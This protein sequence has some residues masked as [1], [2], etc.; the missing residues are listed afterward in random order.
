MVVGVEERARIG[1]VGV[2]TRPGA[3]VGQV[4]RQGSQRRFQGR[5]GR[6]ARHDVDLVPPVEAPLHGGQVRL[7]TGE[8][9]RRQ[10]NAQVL[11][12][13]D[14]IG[15][16]FAFVEIPVAG[17]GEAPQGLRQAPEAN[18]GQG[19]G[20]LTHRREAPREKYLPAVFVLRQGPGFRADLQGSVPVDFHAGL[21]EAYCG[22]QQLGEGTG[23]AGIEHRAETRHHAGHRHGPG[24]ADIGIADD[25]WP[26]EQIRTRAVHE[27]VVRR[28]H[29]LGRPDAKLGG[30]APMI[31]RVVVHEVAA[32]AHATHPGLHGADGEGRG[33]RGVHRVAT[34]REDLGPHA[35]S[36][37][38]LGHDHAAGCFHGRLAQLPGFRRA[39][40]GGDHAQG[41]ALE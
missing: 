29:G 17:V 36:L 24:P 37:D 3:R 7:V 8:V 27:P 2:H 1:L 15:G 9:P 35:G 34:G 6:Q 33:D 26:L 22:R 31:R 11:G 41:L 16:D 4:L 28:I 21:G 10:G 38:M 23:A 18:A 13:L 30:M 20:P 14:E 25:R 12:I 39:A 19:A 32:A 5:A 40:E